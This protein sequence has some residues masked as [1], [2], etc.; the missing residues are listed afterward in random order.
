M[1]EVDD[2]LANIRS[3]QRQIESNSEALR[4]ARRAENIAL[5]RY[6]RGFTSYLDV[7]D[8][9]QAAVTAERSLIQ[10]KEQLLYSHVLLV[11]SLGG[12]WY[13]SNKASDVK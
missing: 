10:S 9:Q 8:A 6:K 5:S 11:K 4:V 12:G 1:R 13:E 7:I 3:W 2:A